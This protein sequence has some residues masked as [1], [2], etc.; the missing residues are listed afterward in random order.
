MKTPSG[1]QQVKARLLPQGDAGVRC[2]QEG[3]P[4]AGQHGGGGAPARCSGQVGGDAACD[5]LGSGRSGTGLCWRQQARVCSHTRTSSVL[6][7]S[8]SEKKHKS[9]AG[10]LG[11]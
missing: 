7:F 8:Q 1:A 4:R 5:L 2:A 11:L 9:Q 3:T 10:S 6:V